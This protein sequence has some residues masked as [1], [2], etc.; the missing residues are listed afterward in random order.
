MPT[1]PAPVTTV[2]LSHDSATRLSLLAADT[3]RSKSQLFRWA[4]QAFLANPRPLPAVAATTAYSVHVAIRVDRD[5]LQG[6]R[7]LAD[8]MDTA[9]SD[10]IRFALDAWMDSVNTADSHPAFTG[11]PSVKREV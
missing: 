6:L 1:S 3:E 5:T 4:I 8:T 9:P 10:L 2:R 11:A 7:D